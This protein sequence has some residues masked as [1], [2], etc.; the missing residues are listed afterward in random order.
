ME[1]ER[2]LLRFDRDA[3]LD[4]INFR[5]LK[6]LVEDAARDWGV[7]ASDVEI[8]SWGDELERG[9]ELRAERLETDKEWAARLQ[10]EDQRRRDFA[11]R[12]EERAANVA[13]ALQQSADKM[14]D[15]ETGGLSIA[16]VRLIKGD[17]TILAKIPMPAT[18][19]VNW[20]NVCRGFIEQRIIDAYPGFFDWGVQ[21]LEEHLWDK[22]P[23]P[24]HADHFVFVRPEDMKAEAA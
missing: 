4:P 19:I 1:P 14:S 22:F 17:E 16:A 15:P 18:A 8:A 3:T 11:A 12:A 10:A 20:A 21:R 9:L 6:A 7:K 5:S 24:R 23:D 13:L 2:K